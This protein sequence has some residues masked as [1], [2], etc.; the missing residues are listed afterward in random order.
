MIVIF[1][2]TTEGRELS[3]KLDKKGIK[4]IV[5]VASC[6]GMEVMN[7]TEYTDIRVGRM[8]AVQMEDFMRANGI[9]EDG[10]VI[11]ATHPYAQEVT[12]NIKI[13]AQK[14]NAQ[15][16]R[17][18]RDS[19]AY[20]SKAI[21]YH[22]DLTKCIDALNKE[23]IN[24]ADKC[25]NILVTTGSK[26][27]GIF[28]DKIR[29]ELKERMYVRVL[30][31]LESINACLAAGVLP[32]NIIAMHGPFN[33]QMNA[34]IYS[35]YNITTL[36]TKESGS[37]G[38]YDS[39][40]KPALDNGIK[41]HVITRPSS[42]E[43]ISVL[44]AYKLIMDKSS[45]EADN[46]CVYINLVGRGMGAISQY[47][48]E[49]KKAIDNAQIIFGAKRLVEDLECDNIYE[50]Y[51]ADDIISKIQ[52][53]VKGN[54][55][56]DEL[57]VTVVFSGDSGFYSGAKKIK[58]AVERLKC[59]S[60][61]RY[62]VNFVPGISSVSYL[63]SLTGES[64]DDA[65]IMSLH[66]RNS[67][68]ELAK[69]INSILHNRKTFVL[70]SGKEDVRTIG[71]ELSKQVDISLKMYVG[72]NMSYPNEK[73]IELSVTD[74]SEFDADGICTA[75]IINEDYKLQ[76]VYPVHR[77]SDFIRDKVP[78]TKSCIRHEA[79]VRLELKKGDVVYDVG[80]GTG[81]VSI[82]IASLSS[83]I[84]V[85]AIEKKKEAIE[86]IHTNINK[87][88]LHNVK[89]VE[90]MAPCVLHDLE[91][92]DAVFIGGTSG[93]LKAIL[94]YINN[95]KDNKSIRVVITAV[96]L[97][98]L[99]EANQYIKDNQVADVEITQIAASD[100]NFVGDYSMLKASNPVFIFSFN[101]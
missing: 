53:E 80:A 5:S 86:L 79:V 66:G 93:N 43:G 42:E 52:E 19:K 35:Q 6:Y 1:S 68:V 73:L 27:I 96:S 47:T 74:A 9:S 55:Y 32:Q 83:D 69:V 29:D 100:V 31:S 33:E 56:N 3:E 37:A 61:I 7:S 41:C 20:D 24:S 67:S 91:S 78:M 89:T 48:F 90:G 76:H 64:Y 59:D 70:L 26:E 14:C 54:K 95:N 12:A 36:V 34:A 23:C 88:G 46:K 101:L 28:G 77:D 30:P 44:E 99:S 38:G 92:P 82:D 94:D 60:D 57:N 98:T 39:K 21:S 51:K 72:V 4:H 40:V 85:Y 63:A 58:E 87:F 16:Q 62:Y 2:G 25:G 8:D 97:E 50:L 10:I 13:A 18:I 22:D 49:A 17:V 81:S 84:T 71:I 15:Y 11:D 75:L 65:A 45:V